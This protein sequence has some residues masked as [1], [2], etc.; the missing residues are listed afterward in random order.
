[1]LKLVH[2]TITYR[3]YVRPSVQH[4]YCKQKKNS[5]CVCMEGGG[6][7]LVWSKMNMDWHKNSTQLKMVFHFRGE[8]CYSSRRYLWTKG[9]FSISVL[10]MLGDIFRRAQKLQRY[11]HIHS[12]K[13]FAKCC[14]MNN[15]IQFI[16]CANEHQFPARKM[17]TQRNRNRS[18]S[19]SR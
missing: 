5:M 7:A 6:R 2:N 8:I 10:I 15:K 16:L 4:Q 18:S 9:L 13:K 14:A 12:K 3:P 17:T 1:M 11:L 19:S